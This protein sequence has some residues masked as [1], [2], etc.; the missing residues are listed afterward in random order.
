[1]KRL[2]GLDLLRAVAIAWVMLYHAIVMGVMPDS[3]EVAEFGWMGS[4]M[5]AGCFARCRHIS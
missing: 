4:S 3:N 1:M 2:P 5:R